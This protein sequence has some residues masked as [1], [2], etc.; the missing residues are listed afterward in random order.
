MARRNHISANGGNYKYDIGDIIYTTTS[1]MVVLEQIRIQRRKTKKGILVDTHEKGYLLRCLKDGYEFELFESEI[2]KGYG[3]PVCSNRKVVKGIND[4]ATTHPDIAKLFENAEDAYTT[5]YST[6]KKFKFKCPTCGHIK[7]DS[8]NHINYF[9]FSCP[10]CSDG[11]SYPNKFMAKL[12]SYLHIDFLREVK[13]DWCRYPC[14]IDKN[15]TDYGSYD[16]VIPQNKLIVEMDGGLGHGKRIMDTISHNRR[17]IS[18]EETIYRDE[19]KNILAIENGYDIIRIGCDYSSNIQERFDSVVNSIKNSKFARIFNLDD[20][21]FE[22][23]DRFC[24]T[25]SYIGD[26]AILWNQGL[27]TKQ[28]EHEMKLSSTTVNRYLKICKRLN[29]CDYDQKTSLHRGFKASKIR[30]P[31]AVKY[32]N[33]KEIF[34][35]FKNMKD[36]YF[37]HYGVNIS[38]T[39]VNRNI[40]NQTNYLDRTFYKITQEEFDKYYNDNSLADL[41]VGEAF[42]IA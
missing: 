4:V 39:S 14:F 22:Q 28:I 6:A 15:K 9:G 20:V 7:T 38:R 10:A 30:S 42:Y 35:S 1:S 37:E 34:D 36:Y 29:L 33:R 17:K 5:S 8:T 23:I 18:L 11:I 32:Q 12:L 24:L 16:F 21:D 31:Y 40:N 2:A 19:M 27:S 41:V 26:I 13:F 3:C 25:N